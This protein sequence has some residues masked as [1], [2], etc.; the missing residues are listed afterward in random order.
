MLPKRS[1]NVGITLWEDTDFK[2]ELRSSW[3]DKFDNFK[4]RKSTNKYTYTLTEEDMEN[5]CMIV[6]KEKDMTGEIE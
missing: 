2:I 6:L 3:G 1:W 4:Y 5:D